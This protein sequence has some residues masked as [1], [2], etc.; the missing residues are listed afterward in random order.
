MLYVTGILWGQMERV[1]KLHSD[2]L[3]AN[4][5]PF[6]VLAIASRFNY[7][8]GVNAKSKSFDQKTPWTLH[9]TK[10]SQILRKMFEK[11]ESFNRC[12]YELEGHMQE[13]EYRTT[14]RSD[15]VIN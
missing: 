2:P 10:A 12:L 8:L 13:F 14:S 6:S 3:F 9:S 5:V 15:N 4:D 1:M 7:R 11:R